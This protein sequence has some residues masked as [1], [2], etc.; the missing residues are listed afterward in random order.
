MET[1]EDFWL[2][3]STNGG[4]SYTTVETWAQ[5]SEFT[6][7]SF[8]N[9]SVTINGPFSA[10]TRLRFRNDAS[11]NSDWIYIDDVVITGCSTSGT[12]IIHNGT[13]EVANNA[14]PFEGLEEEFD[15]EEIVV[16]PNPVQ[17]ILQIKNL[18]QDASVGLLDVSG[19]V[20]IQSVQQSTLDVSSLAPGMYFLR[21]TN[22]EESRTIKIKK[23]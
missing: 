21:V 11:G 8:Y 10:N 15:M 4:S 12:V 9:E 14:T 13:N 3:V 20:L 6:N 1:N 5:G 7:N 2:Q 19:R 18:P 17:D 16:Y 22:G 23:N